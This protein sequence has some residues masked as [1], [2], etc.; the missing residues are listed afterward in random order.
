MTNTMFMFG[1]ADMKY[2][3]NRTCLIQIRFSL[4]LTSLR[5]FVSSVTILLVVS[6]KTHDD[7]KL[8]VNLTNIGHMLLSMPTHLV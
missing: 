1:M 6:C 7:S 4:D 2:W 3:G 8:I 5:K